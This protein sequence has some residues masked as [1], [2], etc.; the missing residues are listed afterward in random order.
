MTHRLAGYAGQ[1]ALVLGASGFIGQWVAREL[2]AAGAEVFL[3][4]RGAT[5]GRLPVLVGGGTEAATD[6]STPGAAARLISALRPAVTFNLA[7]YGVNPMERDPALAARINHSL[8]EEIAMACA[9][10]A[11]PAWPGQDIVHAGSALEYGTAKGSLSE[12]TEPSP[13]TLY[14]QTKLAGTLALARAS[15]QGML[16]AVTA[17]LFTVY[18]PGE[19]PGRLLPSLLEASRA[20]KPVALTGGDQRRDFTYV[21]DVAEGMLRLGLVPD[22]GLGPVNLATGALE[23]VRGF[24]ERAGRVLGLGP[25]QLK[26]GELPDRPDE[27]AHDPVNTGL[28]LSLCR[29]RPA[30]SIEE[31]VRRTRDWR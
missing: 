12:T 18:G 17:R 29:W 6:L 9:G 25:G 3:G 1:R 30:T 19:R 10:T 23:S 28:L 27:M 14:G 20:G 13:T 15:G 21:E 2:V 26:F 5:D 24:V 7:G 16:R 8:V 11:R 4:S 22:A 31:G